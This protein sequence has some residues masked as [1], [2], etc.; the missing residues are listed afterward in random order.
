MLSCIQPSLCQNTVEFHYNGP[1]SNR[2]LPMTEAVTKSLK[3]FFFILYIGNHRNPPITEKWLV[4]FKTIRAGVN[5]TT[6]TMQISKVPMMKLKQA[7]KL[8][9]GASAQMEESRVAT[10]IC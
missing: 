3:K 1:V 10:T 7:E 4:P 2:N 8:F 6:I 5:C 9:S